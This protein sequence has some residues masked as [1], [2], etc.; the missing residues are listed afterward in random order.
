[1]MIVDIQQVQ[2]QVRRIA[3]LG[4]VAFGWHCKNESMVERNVDALDILKVLRDGVVSHEPDPETDMKFRVVGEDIR[5]E[6]LTVI[7]IIQDDDS[8]FIKTVW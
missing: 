1:M 8:L 2:A 4:S 3:R 7:I 5:R 6:E